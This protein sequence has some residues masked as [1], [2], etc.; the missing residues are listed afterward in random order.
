MHFSFTEDIIYNNPNPNQTTTLQLHIFSLV[1]VTKV[2]RKAA[3][4]FI[5]IKGLPPT[6]TKT[7][8]SLL[9][10]ISDNAFFSLFHLGVKPVQPPDFYDP[11]IKMKI[12]NPT[13]IH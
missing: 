5:F 10:L 9:L 11:I 4:A 12:N 6:K 3:R 8:N 7:K 1:L 2:L 13:F